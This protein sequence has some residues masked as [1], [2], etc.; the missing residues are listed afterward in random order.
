[1]P[2]TYYLCKRERSRFPFSHR[3][4]D[5]T[6]I[7]KKNKK[8]NKFNS[9]W[10]RKKL[11]RIQK[12]TNML[13]RAFAL[14][15]LLIKCNALATTGTAATKQAQQQQHT[16]V[17]NENYLNGFEGFARF[18]INIFAFN[19]QNIELN[20]QLSFTQFTFRE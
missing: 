20:R 18:S 13:C 15:Y 11:C 17:G 4:H 16:H 19:V 5:I 10:Q 8:N 1:M 9:S 2:T 7:P 12:I 3:F 14:Q 6:S